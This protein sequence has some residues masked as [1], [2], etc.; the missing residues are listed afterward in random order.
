MVESILHISKIITILP[1]RMQ[2]FSPE[3]V[4]EIKKSFPTH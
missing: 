2:L 3:L 1:N 4:S